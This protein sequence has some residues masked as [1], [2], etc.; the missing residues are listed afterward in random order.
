[1]MAAKDVVTDP[2]VFWGISKLNGFIQ[3]QDNMYALH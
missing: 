1:M 3:G 2:H